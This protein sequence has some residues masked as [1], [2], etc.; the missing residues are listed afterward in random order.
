MIVVEYAFGRIKACSEWYTLNIAR[1][2]VL[3]QYSLRY[4]AKLGDAITL[5]LQ[6]P[7][8][9]AA[10]MQDGLEKSE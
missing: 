5:S 6:N 4:F 10:K 2:A 1:Y 3:R 7:S 8:H 9:Y